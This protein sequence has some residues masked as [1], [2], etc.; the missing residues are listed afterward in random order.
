ML[1]RLAES[2]REY[3]L[4]TIWTVVLI[5]L[6]SVIEALIPFVTA[7]LINHI[8][9]G[10]DMETIIK[11]GAL[12][13]A[14]AV[15]SLTFG[16]LSGYISSK[17]SAGFAKNLRHDIFEK[18][19]TFSFENIDNF[20]ATSLVTRMTTDVTNVQM[21]YMMTIRIA[22]RSPLLLTFS[23]IMA[24]IMGG[25]LA[26]SFVIMGPFLAT[27]L[28]LVARFAMPA[29]SRVFKKYDKL[30]ESINSLQKVVSGLSGFTSIFGR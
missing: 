16:G 4:P 12:L 23:I 2:I 28:I 29:F 9:S 15:V 13:V 30:N 7:S 6:E 1:K 19:Q 27:G 18:I 26:F 10:T 14:M 22:V 11:S 17:A 3:K 20:S 21:A 5:T 24:F 25:K 8:Q